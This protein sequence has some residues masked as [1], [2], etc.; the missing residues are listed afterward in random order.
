MRIKQA[1]HLPTAKVE[2]LITVMIFFH[3]I[4]ITKV[5]QGSHTCKALY[6]EQLN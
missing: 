1:N 6:N 2:S 3:I 5:T 4:Q